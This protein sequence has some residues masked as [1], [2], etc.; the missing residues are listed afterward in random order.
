M[1]DN[2]HSGSVAVIGLAGR[3]PESESIE[4]F[5]RLLQSGE[6]G[7]RRFS[8]A[9]LDEL[10]IPAETYQSDNFVR[11]GSR[12]PYADC[13]DAAFFGFTPREASI[14]DPQCRV[15]LETCY[16]ALENAGCDPYS[17]PEE[18]GV[19][20]GSNPNDYATLLGAADP[21]DSLS[22]F[23]QLIGS[24]KDFLTTRVSHRLNLRGPAMTV[25]TACSTSLVAIHMAAQ[26]LL[27]FECGAALAGGVCLNFRQ[28]VGYFHQPGMIL[29][30]EGRC[31]AFD[32][33][34]SG[35][36]LGQACGVVMLKRLDDALNDR[37]HIYAVIRASAINND[38]ADKAGYTAPSEKGQAAVIEL[39]Q[40]L[41]GV[42]PDE[43]GYVETHGTGTRLGDPVEVAGLT[44]AFS[45]GT[46][47]K[48][49]C[50]IG[51]VKS[52][53]GHTDAAAG[54]SGFIKAVLSL[55]YKMRVPSLGFETP[56]PAIDFENTPFYVGTVL[57]PWQSESQPRVAGVSAFGIG[58]TNAHVVLS[59]APRSSVTGS[60]AQR[61]WGEL[62]VLSAKSDTAA[63]KQVERLQDYLQKS[64]DTDNESVGYTL[65]H[66]RHAFQERRA[67]IVTDESEYGKPSS[68]DPSSQQ[69]KTDVSFLP[70]VAGKALDVPRRLV[71]VFSGQGAQYIA[72][73]RGLYEKEPAF[74]ARF[75]YCAKRFV[76]L[77]GVDLVELLFDSSGSDAEDSLQQTAITQP[78][79]FCVEHAMSHW[80][81]EQGLQPT[82]LIGHSIGEY[83]AAVE[84]GILSLDD[85][86]DVVAAR[87]RLMQSMAPGSML[88]MSV[89]VNRTIEVL[90]DAGLAGEVELAA[91][92]SSEQCVVAGPTAALQQLTTYLDDAGIANQILRTS[93]AFHSRSMDAAVAAFEKVLAS[94]DL[95]QPRIALM[96][97]V[98]GLPITDE[99]ATS[100]A[101]WANQIRQPVAFAACIALALKQP[102]VFMETGPGKTLCN[103]IESHQDFEGAASVAVPVIRHARAKQDDAFFALNAIG[104]AW[105]AGAPVD[106]IKFDRD[107]AV[108]K[109]PLPTYPFE[110]NRHWAPAYLHQLAMPE[111]GGKG[112]SQR[113]QSG[114]TSVTAAGREPFDDW[115]Y[116]PVWE[117]VY[118]ASND[119]APDEQAETTESVLAVLPDGENGDALSVLLQG[120]FEQLQIVRTPSDVDVLEEGALRSCVEKLHDQGRYFSRL[121][122]ATSMSAPTLEH[123]SSVSASGAS[124]D[125]PSSVDFN[126]LL[127]DSL[128]SALEFVQAGSR[129]I[130]DEGS[131][132]VDFISMGAHDLIGN[133]PLNP[134]S[135]TLLGVAKVVPLEYPAMRARHLD[136]DEQALSKQGG[137]DAL[138]SLLLQRDTP[139]I[140]AIRHAQVWQPGVTVRHWQERNALPSTL[141]K[142]GRYLMVGGLGGVGLSLSRHLAETCHA[143]LVLTSRH[144]RPSS[145]NADKETL[146]RLALLDAIENAAASVDIRAVDIT[147]AEQMAEMI[148]SVEAQAGP[149]DGVV[150]TAGVSDQSGSIH[151]R[152]RSASASSMASKVVGARILVDLF[153]TRSVDFLLFSSS[154]ATQLYHNRFAQVGY[155]SANSYVEAMAAYARKRGVPALT[156]AWDDWL[157]VGMS[158]RAASD[159]GRDFGTSVNLVDELN[160]FAPADGVR[161]FERALRMPE[162]LS[163]V[164]PTNLNHRIEQDVHVVSPFLLQALGEDQVPSDEAAEE[165]A[166]SLDSRLRAIWIA[167]LGVA[168]VDDGDDFF[169]LGGDSLQAA[170]MGDRLSRQL[171]VNVPLN[172]IFDNS[173]FD[174][175]LLALAT[176]LADTDSAGD[177]VERPVSSRKGDGKFLLAPA[178]LRF[179]ERGTPNPDHFNISV[180]LEPASSVEVPALEMALNDIVLHNDALRM[181]LLEPAE[182][183]PWQQQ[184][185][186][187]DGVRQLLTLCDCSDEDEQLAHMEASQRSLDLKNG[188]VMTAVLYRQPQGTETLLLVLHH[189]V[190]DRV[191]LLHLIDCLDDAYAARLSAGDSLLPGTNNY[192]EWIERLAEEVQAPSVVSRWTELP[193]DRI[194]PL[195]VDRDN[196]RLE[197][198]NDT[199]ADVVLNFTGPSVEYLL[200]QRLGRPDVFLIDA[201]SDAL[202]GWTGSGC[203]LMDVLGHGRRLFDDLDVSSTTGFFLVY[204]PVLID[205]SSS[206][207]RNARHTSIHDA[208]DNGWQLDAL[209]YYSRDDSVRKRMAEIPRS[210]VL[211]NF[212][213]KEIANDDGTE[214]RVVEGNRGKEIDDQGVRDHLL[215][216]LAITENDSTITLRIVYSTRFHDRETI[217]RFSVMVRKAVESRMEEASARLKTA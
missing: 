4:Q 63:N 125:A 15:F 70:V 157:D 161:L 158:V 212:V 61:P 117:R 205:A 96:S 93:H 86:I 146:D 92:N 54:V 53:I 109:V 191:S 215:S 126:Q 69:D 21:R 65:R 51:S 104:R 52:S 165:Q 119:V 20:A 44:R 114:S 56:N 113:E 110:R 115:L 50:A 62:M 37:D 211:F 134:S 18:I 132:H 22:A 176:Q 105:C 152:T 202:S 34:A 72:M 180:L 24:D 48:G 120:A 38:G 122:H 111:F 23:D 40:E 45:R 138:I 28:G 112:G 168:T 181:R 162:P 12:F 17:Y 213:G 143:H 59:E 178:Q 7:L 216:I 182:G 154:I 33:E 32:A 78:A 98:T 67:F 166:E 160:S 127:A 184:I 193:W 19:F 13:F 188:K 108:R 77:I 9:E 97:N 71:W 3:F 95:H 130:T 116:T 2:D 76:P 209:R 118:L 6:H 99:E 131:L 192:P 185:G 164:S 58:G 153:Q 91:V 174:Q 155:V 79:L 57:E 170:R 36:T 106:W 94:V 140:L 43:V 139:A 29:S 135:A 150:V 141:R 129:F 41:A 16:E 169:D 90:Q 5:W 103:F 47:R 190:S 200:K 196:D 27:A 204:N 133:E 177:Q 101:F 75:D 49:Y 144:G 85:A 87:G 142:G 197:N 167:L 66:G 159:F 137:A 201:I 14:I 25:Q 151:R 1:T 68:D 30:P 214:F 198:R 173:Q 186:T 102:S 100:S 207:D 148:E 10:G 175:L 183:A 107:R 128:L 60:S 171:G 199:G 179:L 55:H 206:D 194:A 80:L 145:E 149:I 11:A 123:V 210:Q 8:D 189:F 124:A 203:V 121:I 81:G 147:D 217:E 39:A 26:S 83:A 172:I 42:S 64:E 35:T 195:P 156:V 82:L 46:Q 187:V 89:S 88:S 74:S 163:Y 73:A 84:A 31:R 136:I 208:L